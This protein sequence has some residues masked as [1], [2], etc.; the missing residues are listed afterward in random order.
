MAWRT[1][2]YGPLVIRSWP[3]FKVTVP[4]QFR[5]RCTRAHTVNK[6]PASVSTAPTQNGQTATG[7]KRSPRTWIGELSGNRS[8]KASVSGTI[9]E[10]RDCS[11][12]RRAVVL[13]L[14]DAAHQYPTQ[15]SHMAWNRYRCTNVMESPN[16]NDLGR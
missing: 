14:N 9:C 11:G 16:A 5:P 2:L 15:L 13:T 6:S 4:L 8:T 7:R 1:N 3:C 12:S 10:S